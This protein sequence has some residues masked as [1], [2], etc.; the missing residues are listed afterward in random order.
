MAS[1]NAKL[2]PKDFEVNS[3]GHVVIKSDKVSKLLKKHAGLDS[4]VKA[5]QNAPATSVGITIGT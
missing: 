4:K 1:E 3:Q 2:N 5:N